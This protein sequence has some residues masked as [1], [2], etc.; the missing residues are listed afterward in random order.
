MYTQEQIRQDMEVILASWKTFL[1]DVLEGVEGESLLEIALRM[2]PEEAIQRKPELREFFEDPRYKELGQISVVDIAT[3][4][5][6]EYVRFF[7]PVAEKYGFG[8]VIAD[9]LAIMREFLLHLDPQSIDTI[10]DVGSG[11]CAYLGFLLSE[12]IIK[13]GKACGVDPSSGALKNARGILDQLKVTIELS[14]D[15]AHALP[16]GNDS[17]SQVFSIDAIHWTERWRDALAEMAR[18]TAKDGSLFV[19]YSLYS[20]RRQP[21]IFEAVQ[22]LNDH[23]I[24]VTTFKEFSITP[25][26]TPRAIVAGK[27]QEKKK[28]IV[29][30]GDLSSLGL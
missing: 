26:Q 11:S 6:A 22:I 18:V 10:L 24:D 1:R 13:P 17:I 9:H 27:K 7:E 12:Q 28:V 15:W 19:A 21:P 23:G 20:P 30:A 29:A 14:K 4:N 8:I 25:G 16:Q 2:T 5:D 3:M